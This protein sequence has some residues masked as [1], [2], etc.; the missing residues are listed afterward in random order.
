MSVR[1]AW[2]L[3][4]LGLPSCF[5]GR[6]INVAV[7]RDACAIPSVEKLKG[8]EADDE[9][10]RYSRCLMKACPGPKEL[11]MDKELGRGS[12]GTVMRVV[13][14]NGN[15]LA[16][17]I[18]QRVSRLGAM[19]LNNKGVA[20]IIDE[21]AMQQKAFEHDLGLEVMD[22]WLCNK[23]GNAPRASDKLLTAYILMPVIPGVMLD[24]LITATRPNDAHLRCKARFLGETSD[25]YMAQDVKKKL[26][27]SLHELNELGLMQLDFRGANAFMQN[28]GKIKF[29]DF[30]SVFNNK[31]ACCV[32]DWAIRTRLGCDIELR[33]KPVIWSQIIFA[34]TD[35]DCPREALGCA[36]TQ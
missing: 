12:F 10:A 31:V 26:I 13:D 20:T 1:V 24:E 4:L 5:G 34:D 14:D 3:L 29:I 22:A 18:I 17:K 11:R 32:L 2:R 33:S 28:D 25:G 7:P 27:E 36:G 21:I 8:E 6:A 9:R 19:S 16:L 15:S 23:E 30:G 35:D